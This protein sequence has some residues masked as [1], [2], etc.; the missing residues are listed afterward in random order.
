M[1][2]VLIKQ[3]LLGSKVK[4]FDYKIGLYILWR[5]RDSLRFARASPTGNPIQRKAV[6]YSF[7]RILSQTTSKLVLL[8]K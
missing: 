7:F 6:D 1:L 3:H 2:R 4:C 5:K 8:Q